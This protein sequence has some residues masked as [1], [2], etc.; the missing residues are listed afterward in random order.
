MAKVIL[1]SKT[2]AMKSKSTLSLISLAVF[3]TSCTTAYKSGQTPDDVYY[4]PAR[5]QEEYVRHE[6]KET[7]EN[8]MYR[9]DDEAYRDDR[10]LRM[11]IQDRRYTSLYD[12]YY[13]YNPYYYHYY[14]G[15][16]LYN[17]PWSSYNYWNCYY[18]PYNSHVITGVVVAGVPNSPVYNKPRAFD[19]SVYNPEPVNTT[20][21][22]KSGSRNS[23]SVPN[24]NSGNNNNYNNSG[25]DAGSFLREVF[26]GGGSNNSS[27]GSSGSSSSRSSNSS[28][29]SSS[30]SSSNSGSSRGN[31]SRGNN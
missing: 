5:P 11:K 16:L 31:A 20:N 13:S 9:Y 22:P 18:N 12:D 8:K 4:S 21:N 29:S 25:R 14:N 24:Y 7:K 28:G 17:S 15:R 27:S 3:V 1:T 6:K 19:L 30:G 26:S 23:H 10:Y 2:S